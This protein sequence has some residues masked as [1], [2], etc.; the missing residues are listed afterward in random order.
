LIERKDDI[1]MVD[2]SEEDSEVDSV[3]ELQKQAQAVSVCCFFFNVGSDILRKLMAEFR[4]DD[5]EEDW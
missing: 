3:D 4:D 2:A 5:S 1:D